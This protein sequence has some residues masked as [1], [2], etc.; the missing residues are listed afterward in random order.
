MTRPGLDDGPDLER[1]RDYLRLVARLQLD[2][3]IQARMDPSD[4]VQQT[5]LE[6]HQALARPEAEAPADLAAYLRRILGRNLVDAVRRHHAGVRDVDLEQSLEESSL[7]LEAWLADKEAGPEEK[8]TR[9]E[10]LAQLADTLV[11]LPEDQRTAVE[12]KYLQGQTVAAIAEQMQR[13]EE[14]VG[15]LLRRGLAGLRQRFKA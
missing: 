3:R 6:A 1:F 11:G 14:A 7:R 9:Q 8:L 12:L 10:Q 5:L 4:L 2:K 13:S 15:G